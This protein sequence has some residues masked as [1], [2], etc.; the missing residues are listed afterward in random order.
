MYVATIT[1][2]T[3]LKPSVLKTLNTKQRVNLMLR[4]T[5]TNIIFCPETLKSKIFTVLRSPHVHKKSREQFAYK[6]YK[7]KIILKSINLVEILFLINY[8]KTTIYSTDLLTTSI[9]HY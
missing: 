1:I 6:L 5:K 4:K 2:N 9:K 3:H 7:K 8:I